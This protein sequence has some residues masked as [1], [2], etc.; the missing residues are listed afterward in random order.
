MSEQNVDTVRR[1]YE[2]SAAR[3]RATVFSLYDSEVEWDTSHHPMG[4]M[5]DEF[6]PRIG[7]EALRGW[8]HDWY[9]AFEDFE[10]TCH[11][12]IDAGERVVSVGTDRGLGR[13]SGIQVERQ[14]AG[15]WTVRGG[16]VVRV[17]WFPTREEALEAALVRESDV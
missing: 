11:E 17:A 16:K 2:A 14:I 6:G 1:I 12:L 10:H 13:G 5:F 9:A 8:F 7:H 15:V 3:D 4:Q